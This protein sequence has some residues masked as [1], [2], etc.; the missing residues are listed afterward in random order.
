MRWK[1][2]QVVGLNAYACASP[3][4]KT[5]SLFLCNQWFCPE[6]VCLKCSLPFL[7]CRVLFPDGWAA[8]NSTKSV[9]PITSRRGSRNRSQGLRP[10][11]LSFPRSG[12]WARQ[13]FERAISC[14]RARGQFQARSNLCP[15]FLL[16]YKWAVFVFPGSCLLDSKERAA[17]FNHITIYFLNAVLLSTWPWWHNTMC[18]YTFSRLFFRGH[19]E[20]APNHSSSL[21]NL[22]H[23]AAAEFN[24][25]YHSFA[26]VKGMKHI[27]VHPAETIRSPNKCFIE[28]LLYAWTQAQY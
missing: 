20:S 5:P 22:S 25:Q 12:C 23:T 27:N 26:N 4:Y 2:L 6:M 24:V 19:Q 15:C 17:F 16:K 28:C 9:F 10:E 14:S 13:T 8:W 3:H 7:T 1:R 18:S 11:I 21:E